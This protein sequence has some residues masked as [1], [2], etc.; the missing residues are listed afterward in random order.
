M[1]L[2][3]SCLSEMAPAWSRIKNLISDGA[4]HE[5]RHPW[6]PSLWASTGLSYSGVPDLLLG[7]LPW[8]ACPISMHD[9]S[10]GFY[11]EIR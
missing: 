11:L 7:L 6:R 2:Q 3:G 5:A 4:R 8:C 9:L 1:V 10:R